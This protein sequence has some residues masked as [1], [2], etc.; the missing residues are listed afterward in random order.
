VLHVSSNKIPVDTGS[1]SPLLY[2]I[3]Q[4]LPECDQP[5]AC[6]LFAAPD[7]D[8]DGRAGLAGVQAQRTDDGPNALS[9]G[10]RPCSRPLRAR[11][12]RGGGAG[13][14]WKSGAGLVPGPAA[15]PW[16]GSAY[17]RHTVSC[18][19]QEGKRVLA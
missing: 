4:H 9:G 8:G 14:L 7:I 5:F 2:A 12:D 15:F 18:D 1:P 13:D 11:T 10:A 19:E 16:G 3:D 6:L 17:E